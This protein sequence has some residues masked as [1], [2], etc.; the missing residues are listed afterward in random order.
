ML[1][2][3][4]TQ[5]LFPMVPC[6]H[7]QQGLMLELGVEGDSGCSRICNTGP[8]WNCIACIYLNCVQYNY[9]PAVIWQKVR[10][11]V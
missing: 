6:E 11:C 10:M 7:S 3:V 2:C 4:K 1:L 8:F 5:N 9:C